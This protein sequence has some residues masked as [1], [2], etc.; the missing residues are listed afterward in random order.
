MPPAP[1]D[2]VCISELFLEC[3]NIMC[4]ANGLECAGRH[5]VR[6]VPML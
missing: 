2:P 5:G 6:A 1:E 4:L 3:G